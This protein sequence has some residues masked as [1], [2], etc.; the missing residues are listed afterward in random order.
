MTRRHSLPAEVY[1][2]VEQTPATVLLEGGKSAQTNHQPWTQLFTAPLR[3]CAA[4]S[5]A[6]IP[7]LFAAIESEIAAGHCAAGFFSY[8]CASCFEPKAGSR[9]TKAGEPLAWFGIYRRSYAF[10][11]A[12]GEFVG[13]EPPE[14]AHFRAPQISGADR[15]SETSRP[16]EPE[17]AAEFALTEVEYVQRI[18]RIHEWIRAGDI[19][20]LNF[21]APFSI[22]APGSIAAHYAWLRSR[23][24]VDYGAFLHWQPGRHILSFSPELFFRVENDGTRGGERRITTKPMKGT[25]PR[26]RTTLEDRQI[27]EWLRGDAKNRSENVMIVD[28]VR[29]DLGRVART[30]SVKVEELFSVERYPTL[31]QMTSTVSAELR[32][33]VGFHD[34]FRALFPCG[35][36]TGAPKVRAMQLIAE[37]EDAP[38]GMY[39]GAIGF[40]SPHQS[41]FNVAIR[42]LELNGTLGTMGAGSGVVIDSDPAG[43]FRECLL[44][45]KFLS[46]PAHGI[47][48]PISE[49][50]PTVSQPDKF[51]LIETMLWDGSYPLLELHLDRLEDSAAYFDYSCDRAAVRAAL[52]DHAR[53]FANVAPRSPRRVRL[54]MVDDEGHIQIASEALSPPSDPNRIG[55][56]SISS[57]QTDPA[58]ATLYHKT[59]HRPI[60]SRAFEQA[61]REGFDDVLFMNLRGEVTEGAISNIFA[62]K[63]GRWFTPP[64]ECGLLAGVYRRHLLQTRP[65]I[66]ERVLFIDDLRN[67]DAIYLA[68]AVRGLRRVELSPRQARLA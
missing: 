16:P 63:D 12:T 60:Y 52:E 21:T 33:E 38:R 10:D 3:V 56:V 6:E 54:L 25:A 36:V 31:W 17:L 66:E 57:V 1:A 45:A 68:N 47:S 64:L 19:Y 50:A 58:D 44:K 37:I 41:V 62:V 26:G 29:N 15:A 43:E 42:T 67:A 22:E 20:Q 4:Y 24:P 13:G 46:G 14:L 11:H 27:S 2:L 59:T 23:Q 40:F 35:S 28:L 55:R 34:I 7:A 49:N 32:P 8:E 48:A 9:A 18:A 30:G 39:T 53:Q 61:A 51:S 65:E 5:A